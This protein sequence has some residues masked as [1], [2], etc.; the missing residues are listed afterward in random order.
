MAQWPRSGWVHALISLAT[1]SVAAVLAFPAAEKYLLW[2]YSR[3]TEAMH[4][5]QTGLSVLAGAPATSL[6]VF[7]GVF[8]L[9]LILQKIMAGDFPKRD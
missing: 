8:L 7:S 4:D 1:S 2:K 9:S 3:D 6:V 5:G